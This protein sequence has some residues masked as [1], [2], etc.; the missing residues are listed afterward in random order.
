[1]SAPAAKKARPSAS[2]SGAGG[3]RLLSA[4][5][6]PYAQ[7]AWISMEEKNHGAYTLENV[8]E[9]AADGVSYGALQL[10]ASS[11]GTMAA[12]HPTLH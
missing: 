7:R 1:M 9:V 11:D 3:V 6:C 4:W 8:M 10:L 2:T 5:F 12:P